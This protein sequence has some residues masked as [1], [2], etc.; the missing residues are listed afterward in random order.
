M[1]CPVIR[2]ESSDR[3]KRREKDKETLKKFQLGAP[4]SLQNQNT[5]QN[6]SPATTRERQSKRESPNSKAKQ[7]RTF[8]L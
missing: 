7:E 1:P 3:Q 2:N 5:H 6:I 4:S 8:L